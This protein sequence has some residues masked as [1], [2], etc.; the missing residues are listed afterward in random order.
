M[1][2]VVADLCE[3]RAG[4][5]LV[6]KFRGQLYDADGGLGYLDRG[7]YRTFAQSI[8]RVRDPKRRVD[9]TSNHKLSNLWRTCE[10]NRGR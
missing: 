10:Q 4:V 9:A 3:A 8:A 2:E 7:E 5:Q 6:Y 1:L